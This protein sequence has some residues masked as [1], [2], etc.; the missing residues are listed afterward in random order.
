MSTPSKDTQAFEEGDAG[1]TAP[2]VVMSKRP[3]APFEIVLCSSCAGGLHPAG[4]VNAD[5][6]TV[7]LLIMPRK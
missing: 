3:T 5:D 6:P 7:P 2:A 1:V 4:R